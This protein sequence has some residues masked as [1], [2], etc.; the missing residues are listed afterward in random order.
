MEVTLSRILSSV[1]RHDSEKGSV[2]MADSCETCAGKGTIQVYTSAGKPLTVPC[3][4]EGCGKPLVHP[5][6]DK[7]FTWFEET[8]DSIFGPPGGSGGDDDD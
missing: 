5:N 7:A 2:T 1:K 3:P 6:V 4:A 8:F